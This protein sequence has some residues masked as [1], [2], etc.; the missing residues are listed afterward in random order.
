MRRGRLACRKEP[1]EEEIKGK[2]MSSERERDIE[3]K[4]ER[5]RE[6][7]GRGANKCVRRYTRQ[8]T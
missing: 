5:G 8:K 2:Q 6:G 3:K 7:D 1:T 4:R